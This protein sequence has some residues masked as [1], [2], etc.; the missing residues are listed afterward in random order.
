MHI[1]PGAYFWTTPSYFFQ[2]INP[3]WLKLLRYFMFR[4]YIF[5]SCG[6]THKYIKYH[7]YWYNKATKLSLQTL[8]LTNTY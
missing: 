7:L 4:D 2:Y 1:Y 8:S 5:D 6:G 3:L